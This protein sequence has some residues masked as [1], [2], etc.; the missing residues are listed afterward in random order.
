VLA[1][2]TIDELDAGDSESVTLDGGG[3]DRNVTIWAIVDPDDT[4]LECND[5]NNVVEGP[6]L[7]CSSEPH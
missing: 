4:I 2:E 7:T 6:M 1:E 3:L 5:A